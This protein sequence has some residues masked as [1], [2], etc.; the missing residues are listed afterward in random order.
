MNIAIIGAGR[1]G[2]TFAYHL[3]KAR[4]DV[5]LV[6][7]GARLEAL[8]SA[9]AV[10][11]VT[12]DEA[13]VAA[14]GALDVSIAFDL[15]LVTV[16]ADQV[17]GLLPELKASKARNIMFMFNS[18]EPT[19]RLREAVG[20]ERAH[21]GF[22]NMTAFFIDGR[23]KSTVDGPGMATTLS[24][25]EWAKVFKQAGMPTEV[26]P[27]M[28]S[29]LRSHV[30]FVVPLFAAAQL[31]WK[32]EAN[33]SWAE[34]AKLTEALVEALELV[35]GLG[36]TLKPAFVAVLA[37]LPRFMLV[38]IIWA[39]SRTQANKGLGEFGPGET[40]SLIDAMAAAAPGRAQKL[41]AIRP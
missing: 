7:R 37:K 33:I 29:F 27:D 21:F 14:V 39:F 24:S 1:I 30:A 6:A 41:L 36:H 35:R 2:S 10:V 11:T 5:T 16:L 38:G 40:R 32:R 13:K 34:A 15:V 22:P 23:L 26:E 18:F 31:T 4:H 20:V 8:K 17:D 9:G 19:S 12:G 3:G 28:D 25:P